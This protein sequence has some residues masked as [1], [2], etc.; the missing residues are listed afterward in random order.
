M[1]CTDEVSPGAKPEGDNW[2]FTSRQRLPL[3]PSLNNLVPLGALPETL[4]TDQS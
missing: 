2:T 1:L 4:N 3:R